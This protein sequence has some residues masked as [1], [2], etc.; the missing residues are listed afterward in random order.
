MEHFYPFT[1]CTTMQLIA[2][3][4]LTLLL[5]APCEGNTE[6]HNNLF[7]LQRGPHQRA[8]TNSRRLAASGP[9]PKFEDLFETHSFEFTG[10]YPGKG[11]LEHRHDVVFR[12]GTSF[13]GD[14]SDLVTPTVEC[15]RGGYLNGRAHRAKREAAAE[16][17]DTPLMPGED[18]RF[19]DLPSV[20]LHLALAPGSPSS[21]VSEFMDAMESTKVLILDAHYLDNSPTCR[22][23]LDIR[24]EGRN[25][26]P[27]FRILQ[28][29]H[30]GGGSNV[31]L[32]SEP[33]A[34]LEPF[35]AASW[36]SNHTPNWEFAL[37]NRSETLGDYTELLVDIASS[38]EGKRALAGDPS[39]CAA[40]KNAAQAKL[41][42]R[43]WRQ[44]K[45]WIQ[46][47][48]ILIGMLPCTNEQTL[49]APIVLPGISVNYNEAT[50]RSATQSM[51][52]YVKQS[53]VKLGAETDTAYLNVSASVT[54]E[55]CYLFYNHTLS[56]GLEFC[57]WGHVSFGIF[58][59]LGVSPPDVFKGCLQMDL[60]DDWLM[61]RKMSAAS[62]AANYHL[63]LYARY[64][65][66]FG[67][68][69]T[70]KAGLNITGE[71]TVTKEFY[72]KPA[73]LPTATLGVTKTPTP[74]GKASPSASSGAQIALD[75][76][77][78]KLLDLA[79]S[80]TNAYEKAKALAALAKK[81]KAQLDALGLPA[82][83]KPKPVELPGPA[84]K[85]FTT[86]IGPIPVYLQVS[87]SQPL[88]S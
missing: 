27:I 64:V 17:F 28:A 55:N 40:W 38:P 43:S 85:V 39:Q 78:S 79:K 82:G 35:L 70:M 62:A 49:G 34:L 29:T 26:S 75:A 67:V 47:H 36:S 80:A 20:S 54:C 6:L 31:T 69:A 53:T 74:S 2:S 88:N 37:A 15:V 84:G 86:M 77:G 73:S 57:A 3:L 63:W 46:T 18:A 22:A 87:S 23:V 44:T 25:F 66:H 60:E 24:L 30:E 14:W 1:P 42:Q 12:Q 8:K 50:G 65:A 4:L 19:H 61:L 51:P 9:S 13:L 5:V 45:A 81:Y 21:L 16:G 7:G 10:P 59:S 11:F 48:I 72:K 76:E 41:N 68:G 56:I 58:G 52:I 83:Q 33:G 32:Y 71:G